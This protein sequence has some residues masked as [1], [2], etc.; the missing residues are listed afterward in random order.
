[1]TAA[2][3][4][5]THIL[6]WMRRAPHRLTAGEQRTIDA[7]RTVFVS[8]VSLWE[9]AILM[10][11]GRIGTDEQLLDAP[12]GYDLLSITA[13]HC[14]AVATLPLHHRD[15]FDRMLVAQARSEHVPL[16]TRDRAVTA[17]GD[18]AAILRFPDP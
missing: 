7:A 3:L 17:Y 8:I 15:P 13:D 1:V 11:L 4:I 5:D 6:L 2:L 18:H 12:G 10:V 9:C 16:L 14:K